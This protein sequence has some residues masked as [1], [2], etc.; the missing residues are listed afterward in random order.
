MVLKLAHLAYAGWAASAHLGP[1]Y[2]TLPLSPG[3]PWRPQCLPPQC[4]LLV[5]S[6]SHLG[7]SL[8]IKRRATHYSIRFIYYPAIWPEL[9]PISFSCEAAHA[10][11]ETK[12]RERKETSLCLNLERT[13]GPSQK[14]GEGSR[15]ISWHLFHPVETE[16]QF[17]C[18]IQCLY[19]AW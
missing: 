4:V 7:K 16:S 3:F 18:L 5:W 14:Q 1:L 10:E 8:L 17:P 13:L 9:F 6:A 11:K 12:R 2:P 19:D 15:K